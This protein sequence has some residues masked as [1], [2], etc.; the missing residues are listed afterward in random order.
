MNGFIQLVLALAR[1]RLILLKR[2]P[3]DTAGQLLTVALLFL[4]LFVGGRSIVG[5]TLGGSLGA[6]VIGYFLWT[7]AMGS[8]SSL[9]QTIT[10]E[11]QWGTLEQLYVS[12]RRFESIAAAIAFVFLLETFVWGSAILGF[13]LLVTGVSLHVDLFTIVTIGMLSLCTAIGIGFLMGGLA[14]LYKRIAGVLGLLQFA[15]IGFIAAPV[16]QYSVLHSVPLSTGTHLLRI[17]ME[18]GLRLWE[19]PPELIALLL[20]KAVVYVALG[21]VALRLIVNVARRRGVIGQY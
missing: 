5:P 16:A 15:F 11:T 17:S 19:L 12:P 10:A 21:M 13:M 3:L 1:R 6:V 8:Y 2:Y 18:D 9:A 7:M 4:A 14:I 20:L